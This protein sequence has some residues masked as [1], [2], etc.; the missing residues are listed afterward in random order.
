MEYEKVNRATFNDFLDWYRENV[1]YLNEVSSPLI[2][3]VDYLD[4]DGKKVC[5]QHAH[6]A[7]NYFIRKEIYRTF[8]ES[9]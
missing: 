3:R 9:K 2:Y 8:A 6:R 5:Y 1:G 7:S 4:N